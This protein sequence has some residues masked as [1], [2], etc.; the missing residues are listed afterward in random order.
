MLEE[1]GVGRKDVV[2]VPLTGQTVA[3][4][5]AR[6]EDWESGSTRRRLGQAYFLHGF[7]D[8]RLFPFSGVT[9]FRTFSFSHPNYWLA[10]GIC[11]SGQT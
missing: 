11:S 6:D 9:F 1:D 10:S 2:F 7:V 8:P 4:H 3:E 5:V